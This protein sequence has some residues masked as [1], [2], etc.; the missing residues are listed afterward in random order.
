MNSASGTNLRLVLDTNVY[1]S[2]F[3]HR[4]GV[5]FRIWQQAVMRR[6]RLLIS[7]AILREVAKVLRQK[8]AWQEIRSSPT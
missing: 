7:P 3:T 4:K 2:A 8:L 1:F 6:Y 5:P